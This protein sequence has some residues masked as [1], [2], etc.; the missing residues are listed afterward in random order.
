MLRS[1]KKAR[2]SRQSTVIATA[3]A[4][5]AAIVNSNAALAVNSPENFFT[6]VANRLLQQ[7]LGTRLTEVQIA[8][9]NLYDTAVHRILQVTANIYDAT[10][11]NAFPAVFRPL[12]ET[13]SNG[14][15]LA[16]FTNDNSVSTLGSWLETNPYGIP[17]V[18]AMRKGFPNFNELTMRSDILVQ[19]KLQLTRPNINPGTRP[20]GT[21]Q[22][23]LLGISNYFG[24][25]AWNSYDAGK[26]GPYPQTLTISVSNFAT[27]SL[28]N[29][30]GFQTNQSLSAAGGTN[31]PA[32]S[33]GGNQAKTLGF[34]L[35]FSTNQVF[36]SNAVYVFTANQFANISTNAFENYSGFPIPYWV[37][38]ISNHLSYL[39]SETAGGSERIVDFVL[40]NDTYKVDLHKEL[41]GG[42]NPY[43]G[44]AGVSPVISQVW[45]TNRS[46]GINGLT[47]GLLQQLNISL[48]ANVTA[49]VD[50]R[51]FALTATA[52][53][54][55]KN[56]VIDAF[57]I[58]C[59]LAPLSPPAFTNAS[60]AMQ[61]PFNPAAKL[62]AQVTWQANDPLVHYHLQDLRIGP[63][64]NRQYLKPIHPGTNIAPSSLGYLNARY[65][66]WNGN[67]QR[68]SYP[69]NSDRAA[70][71]PGVRSS[72]DWNFPTNE[73]LAAHW[74]GRVHRGTPW[75]TLYLKAD[76][77]GTYTWTNQNSDLRT[78]PTN[79][80]R[81]VAS[82]ASMLSTNDV[83]GLTSINTMNLNTWAG[84]FAG[85]TVLSN[86]LKSPILGQPPSFE[87]HV[88]AS[89]DPQISIIVD[90]IN[91]TRAA[92]RGEYF[93]DVAA[94]F[95]VPELSSA[96][97][98]LN[99]TGDQP[100]FAV[101]DE[102]YE[103][104]PGQLLS[105]VRADPLGT[106]TR[107]GDSIELHFTAFDG[108]AYR[109]EQSGDFANW[110][111][112][113]EPHFGTNGVFTL[114]PPALSGAQFFRAVLLP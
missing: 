13:R 31:V 54:N 110:S 33:W 69:E 14:V 73:T 29:E 57:R 107:S 111:T 70:K 30:L 75:Q 76:T 102:A 97:P 82:L 18:I 28:S 63:S 48:G 2:R 3:L 106:A 25:E 8:P 52:N 24:V 44:I 9:T 45:N 36:L 43:Q 79:D 88:I 67:P 86:D 109:V 93:P 66:P 87:G 56:A 53:E 100:R 78:H 89:H 32:N 11:T 80:W 58:F 74:L 101:T 10:S 35:P 71:D 72:D 60:L 46:R 34:I 112:V 4:L 26:A 47:D 15:Y 108:Y 55:D 27:M 77:A 41:L 91:R 92:R 114:V 12:F 16:G 17:M 22:M 21:N 40:L 105:L 113:S 98:W 62:S 1:F 99:L 96:S 7:Q 83:R 38:A 5:L 23:Y 65:S 104:L 90:G 61:T 95:S 103:I 37:Y 49:N 59:G 39:M 6:N 94:F 42:I 20:N 64:T 68:S 50:W 51:S 19:R 81:M 84:R 85:L